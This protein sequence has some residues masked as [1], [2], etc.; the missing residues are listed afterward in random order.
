MSRFV[1]P[2]F[3]AAFL[4]LLTVGLAACALGAIDGGGP[5]DTPPAPATQ[6][7]ILEPVAT[8]SPAPST[9]EPLLATAPPSSPI[10]VGFVARAANSPAGSIPA[11][12]RDGMQIAA[13]M[14]SALF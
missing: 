6:P 9:V 12:S 1:S 8:E 5:E 14:D 7:P 10:T 13:S 3:R 4:F 2:S 11:L